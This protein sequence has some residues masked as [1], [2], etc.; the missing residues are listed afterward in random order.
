[1]GTLPAP[2]AAR[3]GRR[4]APAG[5]LVVLAPAGA[6]G[7]AGSERAR[8]ARRGARAAAWAALRTVGPPAARRVRRRARRARPAGA[9]RGG[10]GGGRAH[11]ARHRA[12]P[13]PQRRVDEGLDPVV[14][15]R[16]SRRALRRRRARGRRGRRAAVRAETLAAM[17][18]G[19]KRFKARLK[20]D[21]RDS[22]VALLRLHYV[23]PPAR[24]PRARGLRVFGSGRPHRTS[25]LA[26][27]LG[28]TRACGRM[29]GSVR[30]ESTTCGCTRRCVP[31]P[32]GTDSTTPVATT[33]V[34]AAKDMP[35]A[36]VPCRARASACQCAPAH[37]RA[38]CTHK[39]GCCSR[40]CWLRSL[41]LR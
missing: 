34:H 7:R 40:P 19:Y 20:A 33:Q 32:A 37:T 21:K 24:P 26:E 15:R 12:G 38:S 13:G 4:R 23:P 22:K 35:R 17:Q 36:C 39:Q 28:L 1:V 25:A 8:R 10:A 11:H 27:T 29:Q 30:T 2:D 31:A 41:I 5:A 14:R 16:A 18:A 9:R 6:A 3:H